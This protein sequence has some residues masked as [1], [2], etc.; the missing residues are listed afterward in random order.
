MPH[1]EDRSLFRSRPWPAPDLTKIA[2]WHT[3]TRN[4]IF[5]MILLRKEKH[6]AHPGPFATV[7][8]TVR[9]ESARYPTP[10][11]RRMRTP[12]DEQSDTVSVTRNT[13]WHRAGAMDEARNGRPSRDWRVMPGVVDPNASSSSAEDFCI[14]ASGLFQRMTSLFRDALLAFGIAIRPSSTA[15]GGNNKRGLESDLV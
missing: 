1:A 15:Q 10:R 3:I 7:T 9:A 6:R 11:R 14:E 12:S 5:E 8:R 2:E 13:G 4:P